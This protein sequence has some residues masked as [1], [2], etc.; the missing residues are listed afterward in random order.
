MR[1][2]AR[3]TF[4]VCALHLAQ[5]LFLVWL[6]RRA[7][8]CCDANYYLDAATRVL[9]DGVAF[10]ND[11][12]GYRSYFVPLVIG[13][14]QSVPMPVATDSGVGYPLVAGLLFAMLSVLATIHVLRA[15][16]Y[17]RYLAYALPT[18]FNPF[19]LSFVPFPMQ[20]SV[21]VLSCVPLVLLLLAVRRRDAHW[22]LALAV[23][24]GALAYIIRSSY[25]WVCLP[26]AILVW[27]HARLRTAAWANPRRGKLASVALLC[28]APLIL[29]QCYAMAQA[30]GSWLPYPNHETFAHQIIWGIQ[31]YK[32][33]T[34][35]KDELWT[36]L[37]YA[38]PMMHWPKDE[39]G[40]VTYLRN[41]GNGL[42][43]M[44]AHAWVPLHFDVLTPYVRSEDLHPVSGWLLGS[45]LVVACGVAGLWRAA[46]SRRDPVETPFLLVTVG[47][48]CA[49]TL[50]AAA[51]VRFGIIGFMALSIGAS[52]FVGDA[53]VR[54]E[55][56]RYAPW[57]VLYVGTSALVNALLLGTARVISATGQ[58]VPL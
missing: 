32:Y 37:V 16:G 40:L 18:I 6:A 20:E 24:C 3:Q 2:S 28:S 15:E 49:Y 55:W 31:A 43:L 42:L 58:L 50:V 56:R 48:S 33:A 21:F 1:M 47:L 17:A 53:D 51:E 52:A 46:R 34:V 54:R 13:L 36:G 11:Y 23:S 57:V 12:A 22:T 9:R 7:V 8:F 14:L 30:L 35:L 38:S 4:V 25:L 44:L 45:A 10:Q 26:L 29:P 5:A 27:Q 41:P 39:M 19:L